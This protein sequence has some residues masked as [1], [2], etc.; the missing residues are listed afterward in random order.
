MLINPYAFGAAAPF[1]PSSLADLVYWLKGDLLATGGNYSATL[2]NSA[3]PN[4]A[5]TINSGSGAT[6]G[7]QLNGLN[8]A[9]FASTGYNL[10]TL[11]AMNVSTL[12]AVFN[13]AAATANQLFVGSTANSSLL[14]YINASQ[15][16]ALV[17][18]FVALI[19]SASASLTAS[20]WYQSNVTYEG[21]TG[22]G[23]FAFRRDRAADGS[24]A[25]V[26]TIGLGTNILAWDGA[27]APFDGEIAELIL[28]NRV[29]T[30]TEI[31]D[32]ENYFHAKWGV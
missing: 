8:V 9:T 28:V 5:A 29:C 15:Q 25:H 12:F 30:S 10:P 11:P 20:T 2:P 4:T 3:P 16:L 14:W 6:V 32:V 19:G 7:S 24:G 18:E 1:D 23:N 27:S 21:N 13:M 26:C 22:S 17:S 31:T